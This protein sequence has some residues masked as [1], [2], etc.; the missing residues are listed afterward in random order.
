MKLTDI[1][2]GNGR[3]AAACIALALVGSL[4]LWGVGSA[5]I[6]NFSATLQGSQEVPPNGSTATG[7]GTMVLDT[8]TN[9][10][11]YNIS[12]SGLSAP[13]TAAHFH[14]PAA[15][16]VNAGVIFG[17]G[18]GSPQIGVWNMTDQQ[19]AWLIGGL[20]YVN[21]H[22]TAFPGGEIRGQ[23]LEAPNA[24]DATTWGQIKALYK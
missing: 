12:F 7:S 20:V 15:P 19:E 8:D 3:K 16:G 10:L 5:A 21:V 9:M 24:A 11:S 13:Q 18:L 1:R 14:G 22:T 17:L 2:F 4:G 23:V 6:M